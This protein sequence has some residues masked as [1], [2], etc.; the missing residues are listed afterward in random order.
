MGRGDLSKANYRRHDMS[1]LKVG[2]FNGKAPTNANKLSHND[3]LEAIIEVDNNAT[4][5]QEVF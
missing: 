2:E 3:L 5:L 1:S 4:N